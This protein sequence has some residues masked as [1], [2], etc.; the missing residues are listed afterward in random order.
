MGVYCKINLFKPSDG[1]YLPGSNVSG[2]IQYG[3]DEATVFDKITVSLKGHG[4]LVIRESRSDDK[5]DDTYTNK[6][7]Y[8]DVDNVVENGKK[9]PHDIGM[10]EARF[11]FKLPENIPPSL[12]YSNGNVSYKIKC[13][14][15]YYVRIKFEMSGFLQF[16]KRFKK[17]LTVLSKI[18][19]TLATEP[20]IYGEQKSLF[21]PFTLKKN[22]VNLK[23]NIKNSVIPI[24]GN[25]DVE[26]EVTNDTSIIIKGVEIKLVENHT[27]KGG[28]TVNMYKDVDSTDTKTGSIKSDERENYDNVINVPSD[29]TSLGFSAIVSRNYLVRITVELP[30]PHTNLV[31]DIP[32]EIGDL[33][34]EIEVG[35]EAI[36]DEVVVDDALDYDN[37][38]P[39]YWEV[40]GEMTKVD[41][42]SDKSGKS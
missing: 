37:P 28:K 31:L 6:E 1:A 9:I 33:V 20:I 3:V 42:I 13:D 38:P 7:V 11:D 39:S 15:I 35:K 34:D 19:P 16:A 41:Y 30:F 18:K 26:Y 23:A 25:I 8:V 12:N 4:L 29:V 27:F 14:I 10:Y 21:K 24:G 17:E 36:Q 22:V 5:G 40:M 32:V 2:I